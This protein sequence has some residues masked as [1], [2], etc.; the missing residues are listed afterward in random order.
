MPDALSVDMLCDFGANNFLSLFDSPLL[1]AL[2]RPSIG[3]V[4]IISS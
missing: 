3:R 4:L 2:E 1:V